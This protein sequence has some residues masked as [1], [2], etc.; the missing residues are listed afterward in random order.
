MTRFFEREMNRQLFAK[1]QELTR[2]R[3]AVDCLRAILVRASEA[4]DEDTQ[5]LF[6][7]AVLDTGSTLGLWEG[8]E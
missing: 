1:D 3:I 5:K 6:A 4:E 7:S 8:T 2:I